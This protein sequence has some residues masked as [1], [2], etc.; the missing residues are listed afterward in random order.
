MRV[1]FRLLPLS[2]LLLTAASEARIEQK[3][4]YTKQQSYNAALRYLRVDSGY[5]ITEKDIESG[6]LLF[7][8]PVTGSTEVTGGSIEIIDREDS[9]A[10]IVQLPQMP[11]YHERM[12]ATGLLKKLRADY[13]EPP[14]SRP[15]RR[16]EG[17]PNEDGKEEDG[18]PDAPPPEGPS[19]PP[20]KKK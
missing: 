9:V 16:D 10:L 17:A 1:L 2:L 19:S 20:D 5:K 13:G 12:L 7:E 3:L 8:Y 6:Y 18:S 14:R 4:S 11:R 15:P